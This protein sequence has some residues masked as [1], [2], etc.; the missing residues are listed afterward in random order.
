ML[1]LQQASSLETPLAAVEERLAAL[2]AALHDRDAVRI[3][4]EAAALHRALA[5][6]VDHFGRAA[7]QGPIPGALRRRLMDALSLIHI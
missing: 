4:T 5:I 1:A 7:R 2:G 6:A 3:E